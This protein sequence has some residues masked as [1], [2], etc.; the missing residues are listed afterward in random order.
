M[1]PKQ[2]DSRDRGTEGDDTIVCAG[3]GV[4]VSMRLCVS[5]TVCMCGS[6]STCKQMCM[7]MY[8]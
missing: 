1:C 6:A 4:C 7:S 5:E 2:R 3:G 8:V